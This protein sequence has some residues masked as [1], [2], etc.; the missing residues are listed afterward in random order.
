MD[1]A[2]GANFI[3]AVQHATGSHGDHE[4]DITGCQLMT[5]RDGLIDEV[6]GHYSDQVALDAFWS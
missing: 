5:F 1:V 6:R 2:V 3:V 4:L